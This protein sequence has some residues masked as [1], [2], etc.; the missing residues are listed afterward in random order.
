MRAMWIVI[1][2]AFGSQIVF[3]HTDGA[4]SPNYTPRNQEIA[5]SYCICQ[6]PTG[7]CYVHGN[8]NHAFCFCT[9]ANG[10][11]QGY[12]RNCN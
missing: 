9:G 10:S 3:A 6:T 12:T 11:I 2:L 5:D 7:A 4:Y 8:I 1:S